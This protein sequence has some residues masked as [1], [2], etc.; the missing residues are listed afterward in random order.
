VV[1]E[2][3]R[4]ATSGVIPT[5]TGDAVR[6]PV[7]TAICTAIAAVTSVAMRKAIRNVTRNVSR[8]S[9]LAATLDSVR[10][11][12]C[13]RTQKAIFAVPISFVRR[14]VV[15]GGISATRSSVL[16]SFSLNLSP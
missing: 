7:R 4:T 14:L 2:V 10:G 15:P 3:V 16:S 1:P 8:S 9:T 13:R 12:T 11:A 5:R 6:M